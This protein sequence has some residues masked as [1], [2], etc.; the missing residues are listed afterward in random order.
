M[1]TW[2]GNWG[3]RRCQRE[4][5]VM[6]TLP[7]TQARAATVP[8]PCTPPTLHPGAGHATP[9]APRRWP[10]L[11][12]GPRL[13]W[14][15]LV[16]ATRSRSP[17]LRRRR[18]RPCGGWRHPPP[19]GALAAGVHVHVHV[20]GAVGQARVAGD[21][22]EAVVLDDEGEA[23][24]HAVRE[25]RHR[26]PGVRAARGRVTARRLQVRRRAWVDGGGPP[27]DGPREG[28]EDGDGDGDD[29]SGCGHGVHGWV[30]P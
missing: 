14:R 1:A 2:A 28:L 16:A 18:T 25:A 9:P 10:P 26:V 29:G 27:A 19:V 3:M 13:P 12:S 20:R 22:G 17:G 15:P 5:S 23:Q 30:G 4:V 6:P 7:T 24:A 21:A 11:T 8:C